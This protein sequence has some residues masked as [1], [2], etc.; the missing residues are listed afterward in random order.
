[1]GERV[2][3]EGR[4]IDQHGAPEEAHHQARPA[5]DEKTDHAQHDGRHE[6]VPVQPHQLGIAGEIGDLYEIGGVVPAGKD[7]AQMAVDEPG[8]ARRMHVLV[9]IRMQ[10]MVPMLGRPPQHAL[11]R[12]ALRQDREHEL[13]GAAGR[14]GAVR[15]I[16][17][18]ARA[19]REDA[20]PVEHHADDHR[21]PGD[22]GPDRREAGEMDQHER[23]CRRVHDVVVRGR[24]RAVWH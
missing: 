5:A 15:E 1:M 12:G 24:A 8:V 10:V 7:P 14:I 22:A 19:D 23:H 3:A 13:E 4:V 16:A 18:I 20:Q 9:G 2:D 11:L 17:V 6:L 21:L